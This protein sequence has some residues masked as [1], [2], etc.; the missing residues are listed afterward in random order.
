MT[1][2]LASLLGAGGRYRV[3]GAIITFRVHVWKRMELFQA[4]AWLSL[5][6]LFLGIASPNRH[7]WDRQVQQPESWWRRSTQ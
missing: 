4:E 1:A 2:T 5:A 6:G 7:R 3:R